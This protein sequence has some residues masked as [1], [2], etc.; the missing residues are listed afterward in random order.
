MEGGLA[1]GS[2]E[3][4]VAVLEEG[5]GSATGVEARTCRAAMGSVPCQG[6]APAVGK[7]AAE[8]EV[9]GRGEAARSAAQEA[10][11]AKVA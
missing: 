4:S 5:E 11:A 1:K 10:R 9:I 3:D 6:G 2:E 8:V 7:E